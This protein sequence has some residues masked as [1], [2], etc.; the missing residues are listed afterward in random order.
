M[1]KSVNKFKIPIWA[2]F[3]KTVRE[4]SL[5]YK[6][7]L[8]SGQF[9]L[10]VSYLYLA[11]LAYGLA[12]YGLELSV[13]QD[14]QSAS[15]EDELRR[16]F[17]LLE[18]FIKGPYAFGAL[19]FY[20]VYFVYMVPYIV[21]WMRYKLIKNEPMPQFSLRSLFDKPSK[22]YMWFLAKVVGLWVVFAAAVLAVFT[23][24]A[25]VVKFFNLPDS[26]AG[27]LTIAFWVFCFYGLIWFSIVTALMSVRVAV[28]QYVR[29]KEAY[30]AVKGHIWRPLWVVVLIGIM[31]QLISFFVWEDMLLVIA[32][33]PIVKLFSTTYVVVALASC[34]QQ[35]IDDKA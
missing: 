23:I 2:T 22:A 14:L 34:Y 17:V 21:Q 31:M 29:L 24:G 8:K 30:H 10:L 5:D 3:E 15:S 32:L 12:Q 7:V 26:I 27:P 1:T 35:I 9:L 18:G 25:G 28:G 33:L 4:V 19:L 6:L 13:L 11:L 16:Y 20:I